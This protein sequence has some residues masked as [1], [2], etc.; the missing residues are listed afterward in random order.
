MAKAEITING[1]RYVVS[2][3]EGQ[4]T[5]LQTLGERLDARVQEM[6]SALGDI[7]AERLFLAT[8][9][10]LLDE[11]EDVESKVGMDRLDTRIADI[12]TRAVQALVDA[13][14][15]IQRINDRIEKAG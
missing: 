12:E 8:A 6:S 10:S 15:R 9:I 13:A 11:L 4:E 7:G 14:G 2:C 5:R 1:K 3:E